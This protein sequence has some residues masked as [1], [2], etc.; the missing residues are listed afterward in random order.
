M[1][2]VDYFLKIDGV[3]GE[4]TS[5]KHKGEIEILS[6]SWGEI[7]T[8]AH[9]GGG[10]GGTGKVQVSPFHF[11]ARSSLAS[12]KLILACASGQH[13]QKAVLTA[14]RQVKG[15]AQDYL[16][17]TLT[18][19]LV[20]SFQIGAEGPDALP[21]DAFDLDFGKIEVEYKPIK[22]D[23]SLGSPVNAGWDVKDNKAV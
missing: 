2:A 1:A 7:Q 14:A 10:G 3:Q 8:G 23:G 21:V 13:I 12:P 20:T 19:V 16:I 15:K 6:W 9:A 4:G 18:D 22:A 17:W 5:Q 11:T